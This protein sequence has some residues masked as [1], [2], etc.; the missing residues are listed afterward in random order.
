M[1]LR[2]RSL[3]RQR[4]RQIGYECD[5]PHL[6]RKTGAKT[7]LG[8]PQ[9]AQSAM[10][11]GERR[12]R[13]V[14]RRSTTR[15]GVRTSDRRLSVKSATPL[16]D[17]AS[18][19][20]PNPQDTTRTEIPIHVRAEDYR[21][22]LESIDFGFSTIEVLFDDKGQAIDYVFLDVN[23]AFERQTGLHDAAGRRMRELV[24]GHESHWFE[25]YGEVARTGEPVRFDEPAAALGRWYTV[26]ACRVGDPEQRRVAILFN[27]ISRQKKGLEDLHASEA[28]Y[29]AFAHATA[30]AL[31]RLSAD[32]KHVLE[33]YGGVTPQF[34]GVPPTI[35][36]LEALI[37]PDDRP[38]VSEAWEAAFP[39][40]TPYEVEHRVRRPDGSWA[41]VLSRA[42]PVRD[43]AGGI[44]EWIG[45][46]T[47]ITRR[48]EN[49]EALRRSEAAHLAARHEAEQANRAKDAFVAMVGH[50]LRNPL[51]PMLTA[52]QLL[53]RRGT[54]ARELDVIERQAIHLGRIV[55]DLLDV[56]R[57]ASGKAEL[58]RTPVELCSV[59]A[60][61][62][63]LC[64]GSLDA[65]KHE[66][67]VRIPR[68]GLG[69][70][71]DLER[72][73]QVVANLLTNAAKYSKP[74]TVIVVT[75][76]RDGGAVKLSVI[77]QGIGIAP[78]MLDAVFE[79]FVQQPETSEHSRGGLGLGLAIA[80]SLVEAHGGSL[81]AKSEGRNRGSE[82]VVEL[83]AADV[84]Q[85]GCTDADL[86][87]PDS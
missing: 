57:I 74:G 24:P 85:G 41:W 1:F 86:L 82:F 80:R 49:E 58:K 38:R 32:G 72:L 63:E 46:A 7:L 34:E 27:D 25:I 75:A 14:E 44:L 69:V 78:E 76:V 35:T 60:R 66:L 47:D 37:H 8:G 43:A 15:V 2:N 5:G 71:A 31:Y 50:E 42:V 20:Q 11:P 65:H 18:P 26:Y 61:A 56:A 39:A 59:V 30:N 53:R 81:R 87:R 36:D 70:N 40:Q 62:L 23:P 28:R 55:D 13:R 67:D 68:S 4:V 33:I 21:T 64:S 3:V 19:A 45:S 9:L 6:S 54:E 73:A 17:S 16:T 77:D 79:P 84:E 22:L 10:V 52:V 48:K 29:R 12:R 83:P 51:S